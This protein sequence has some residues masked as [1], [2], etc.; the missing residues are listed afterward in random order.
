M[1]PAQGWH[2]QIEKWFQSF[3]IF[4]AGISGLLSACSCAR[5]HAA[6]NWNNMPFD[7]KYLPCVLLTALGQKQTDTHTIIWYWRG[8]NEGQRRL[9]LQCSFTTINTEYTGLC[10]NAG[11]HNDYSSAASPSLSL[12]CITP[13]TRFESHFLAICRLHFSLQE[14]LANGIESSHFTALAA[15]LQSSQVLPPYRRTML[16]LTALIKSCPSD[17]LVPHS[18]DLSNL[19]N[20][21]NDGIAS[22]QVI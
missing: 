13:R 17:G 11:W 12:P 3:L 1:A 7:W 6:S 22:D 20:V 19:C 9:V 15:S 14:Q 18:G 10:M 4:C 21:N 8:R 2:A 16:D 5:R